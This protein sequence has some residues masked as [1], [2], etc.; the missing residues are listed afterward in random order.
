LEVETMGRQET[1]EDL[2]ELTDEQLGRIY[3]GMRC[4]GGAPQP[5]AVDMSATMM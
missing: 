4:A 1:P 5:D 2:V 3:G